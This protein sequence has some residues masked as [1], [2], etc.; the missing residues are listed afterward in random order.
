[1]TDTDTPTDDPSEASEDFAGLA[2]ATLSKGVAETEDGEPFVIHG[3]ALGSDD[4][5]VG[6]SGIKKKWPGAELEKAASTLEGQPL[7][8]NHENSVEG[9]IGMVTK[10]RFAPGVGVLYEAEIASHYEQF[11]KDIEAGILEVSPRVLHAPVEELDQDEGTGAL[12]VEQPVFDNLSIV[13]KGASPSNSAVSGPSP[14]LSP[15]SGAIDVASARVGDH[16]GSVAV[17]SAGAERPDSSTVEETLAEGSA[18]TG[19]VEDDVDD[20][21]TDVEENEDTTEG[22]DVD[23]DELAGMTVHEPSWSGTR[24]GEWSKPGLEDFTDESWEELSSE[25]K[26]SIGEHFIVSTSGFPAD[27]FGDMGLPVVDSGGDLV[28]NAVQ[29]AKSRAGQVSGLSGDD[30]SRVENI[31]DNLASKFDS[32][33]DS[34]DEEASQDVPTDAPD[35]PDEE[36][37]DDTDPA[38]VDP[39]TDTAETD[40]ASGA[41]DDPESEVVVASASGPGLS[42]TQTATLSRNMDI[43]Y[44]EASDED[45]E[46]MDEAVV[47]EKSELE[48]LEEKASH[49]D[50]LDGRLDEMNSSLDE[51][52]AR[53]EKLDDVDEEALEALAGAD[54]ALV[55]ESGE[56]EELTELVDQVS[57][58]YAEE[59]A[60]HI[61]AFDADELAERYEPIEL[62]EKFDNSSEAELSDELEGE[63]PEP[64]GETVEGEELSESEEELEREER[65]EEARKQVAEDLRSV[66]WDSQAQQVLDGEIGLDAFGVEAE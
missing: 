60:T 38:D 24:S 23:E 64:E 13:D 54:D 46:A 51:L 27:S 26:S 19:P 35:A 10:S 7:V 29:N 9:A 37:L 22:D 8:K 34:D 28:D 16:D 20:S 62:R 65:E 3:V 55:V 5:T 52:S 63:D 2:T 44:D 39:Q 11:A 50:D 59:L 43:H 1:M 12:I 40:P 66:G 18:D 25:Q 57:M 33:S 6:R 15:N 58:I 14:S 45:V 17:L 47:V 42:T 49:A 56:H 53:Q 32:G 48:A 30:L 41:D 21:E 61:E 4:I 36:Q 31:L